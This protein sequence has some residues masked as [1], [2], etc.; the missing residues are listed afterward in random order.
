[1]SF[2]SKR[3]LK[4]TISH[5]GVL[6]FVL[7]AYMIYH[8]LSKYSASEI[9]HTATQIPKL[10]IFWAF[11]AAGLGYLALSFYDF[12]ALRYI[13]KTLSWW[14]W[15]LAGLLGFAV[16]NN[17][18]NAAISG[19]AIRYRLYT[20][21]RIRA[22]DIVKMLTFSGVTYYLGASTVII[23]GYFLM[24]KS[25]FALGG[26]IHMLFC[27]ASAFIGAY[28][29]VCLAF[30]GKKFHI[31]KI[32][33]RIPSFKTAITQA[34]LGTADSILAGLV[35]YFLSRHFIGMS[36]V[37]F[38]SVFVVAQS[39]GIFA[40]VPG[41]IGVFESVVLLAMPESIDK[42]ALF[43][44]LLTFRIIYFLLPLICVGTTFF[45]YEHFLRQRMKKWRM[46]SIHLPHLKHRKKQ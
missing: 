28:F 18:G 5:I 3:L 23:L 46:F 38:L 36:P 27:V 29:A 9:F 15:M 42:A 12:I 4:R 45:I 1:M 13:G 20:R 7:A 43:G 33:F 8:Q 44:S 31:G 24:P 2:K 22:G 6:F 21:W 10:N 39:A 14:K 19:G 41:G 17:A 25:G 16:S 32:S 34:G 35:L 30:R 11:V 40:Q 26:M 37:E